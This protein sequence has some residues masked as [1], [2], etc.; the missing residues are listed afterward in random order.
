LEDG[1]SKRVTD[2]NPPWA[3]DSILYTALL[4]TYAA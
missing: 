1:K 2:I 3:K 4:E